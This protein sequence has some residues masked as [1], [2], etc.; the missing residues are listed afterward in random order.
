VK[1]DDANQQSL[2]PNAKR[3]CQLREC[4]FQ[5]GLHPGSGQSTIAVGDTPSSAKFS[6]LAGIYH[7]DTGN[8]TNNTM[9]GYSIEVLQLLPISYLEPD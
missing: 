6:Q 4:I 3:R 5:A 2:N 1:A 9:P 7:A 8:R